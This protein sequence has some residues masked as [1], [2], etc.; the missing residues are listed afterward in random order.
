MIMSQI[1]IRL[2]ENLKTQAEI[3]FAEM[4]MN[5]TTAINLFIRQAVREKA[6]PFKIDVKPASDDFTAREK[7]IIDEG[8][9]QSLADIKAGRVGDGREW[10]SLKRKELKGKLNV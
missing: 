7:K 9:K 1:N 2:D 3:L 5:M 6:I 10:L 4:G 8:L